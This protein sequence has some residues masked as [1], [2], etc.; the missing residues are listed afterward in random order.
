MLNATHYL[1]V[2]VGGAGY[3]SE[4]IAFKAGA[5]SSRN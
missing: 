2:A 4:L 5:T 1:V 3:S